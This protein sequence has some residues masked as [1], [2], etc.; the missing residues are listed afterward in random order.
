MLGARVT[1]LQEYREAY[2]PEERE[3]LIRKIKHGS[4][5]R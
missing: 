1:A 5:R 2:A 4:M 3:V